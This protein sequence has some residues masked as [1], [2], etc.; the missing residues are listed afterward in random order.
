MI[1]I[2]LANT[3]QQLLLKHYSLSIVSPLRNI[4]HQKRKIQPYKLEEKIVCQ[5]NGTRK[6]KYEI[7]NSK[8]KQIR[9]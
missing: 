3:D 6:T 9:L 8:R 2:L 1:S 7:N 4:P 5:G